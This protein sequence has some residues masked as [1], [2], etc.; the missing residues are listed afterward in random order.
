M[1]F[2][3]S[4]QS[5][6]LE[7][8]LEISRSI[9]HS[10]HLESF[11]Q[12]IVDAAC[13]LIG[14][15][16]SSI[17]LIEPE[18]RYLKFLAAPTDQIEALK[19]L[20][21]PL[22]N[23]VAG[24]CFQRERTILINQ[25]TSDNRIFREVDKLL[26]FETRS[27]LAQPLRFGGQTIGVFEAVN[28]LS[29]ENFSEEDIAIVETL[30]AQAAVAIRNDQLIDETQRRLNDLAELDKMKA[31]FIAI[32][33]HELRTPLGLILGHATILRE[34]I[35]EAGQRKQ[36]DVI[37]QSALR[38]KKIIDDLANI[39]KMQNEKIVLHREIIAADRLVA[40]ILEQYE[41]LA[42]KNQISLMSE[43]P[44]QN[45]SLLVDKEKINIAIGN[46]VKN[47]IS[48]TKAGGHVLVTVENLLG[49]VK[50]SVI[51][52]G[53]GIPRN[54]LQRIFDRF[55]QVES[56]LTRKV[57]GMGLGLSVAKAMV[58]LHGG[59]IWAESVEGKGSNFSLLLPSASPT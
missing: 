54:E 58:E 17:L 33:S 52:D 42:K 59:Q 41:G 7:R 44:Q 23:S 14:C 26:R 5:H 25:A 4:S 45:L 10:Y 36:I 8:L 22:E 13:E 55:Y 37:I 27:I 30:A 57:G 43:F 51:D 18:T 1:P 53:I 34:V 15:E 6:S 11:L 12:N 47:A 32:A 39:Q 2:V 29:G 35:L 21:I 28:K 56:H 48:F 3:A 46:L 9:S 20:R 40:D 49:Y 19:Q 16:A 38:L 24:E 50:I 31:D